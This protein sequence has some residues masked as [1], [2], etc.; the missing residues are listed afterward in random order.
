MTTIQQINLWV[1]ILAIIIHFPLVVYYLDI[2]F[3]KVIGHNLKSVRHGL[4][5][6]FCCLY[7]SLLVLSFLFGWI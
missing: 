6:S 1:Q 7:F 2:L 4:F 5:I 3:R